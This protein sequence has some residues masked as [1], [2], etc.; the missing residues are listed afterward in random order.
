MSSSRPFTPDSMSSNNTQFVD[1]P[2]EPVNEPQAAPPIAGSLSSGG[3]AATEGTAPARRPSYLQNLHLPGWH[4]EQGSHVPHD[5]YKPVEPSSPWSHATEG[6]SAA[7]RPS[8]QES[9]REEVSSM[10]GVSGP[11]PSKDLHHGNIHMTKEELERSGYGYDA[12]R[13]GMGVPEA[14]G[15]D[16]DEENDVTASNSWNN[17]YA[18]PNDPEAKPTSHGQAADAEK[19]VAT[20]SPAQDAPAQGTSEEAKATDEKPDHILVKW[21][22]EDDREHNMQMSF[23]FRLYLTVIGGLMTLASTFASSAPSFAM[24]GVMEEFH[25]KE[26]V[27]KAAVFLFVGGYCFAPLIW[28]PLSEMFGRRPTFIASMIG[29]FAFNMGCAFCKNIGS[30]IVFRILAGAF[31]SAPLSNVAPMIGGLFSFK[32]LTAGIVLFAIA[33]M[34]GPCLGPI[35]GGYIY[36]SGASWRWVYRV[37]SAVAFFFVLIAVFT[38]PETLDALRLKMKAQRLRKE[39]GDN[40]YVAPIEIR[41]KLNPLQLAKT[42]LLKPIKLFF[43]EPML[44]AVTLYISFVYGTL[45]LLFDAY[46]VVFMEPEP[47][48]HG[49][50]PGSVGLVF[51]G[52]F[53]GSLVGAAYAI[54]VDNRHYIKKLNENGGKPPAPEIRL[55]MAMFGAPLLV[56]SLFWFAWT[57]YPSISFWSPLVAGGMFGCAMYTIFLGLM[58]YMTEVYLFSAASAI[59]ANTVVRSAFGVGFPMFGTGMYHNL[60][61]QWATTILAF[62]ALAMFPMPFILVKYGKKLRGMSKFAQT[63]DHAQ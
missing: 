34:S 42:V 5:P 14:Q 53:V 62:I 19:E 54:L 26:E 47:R 46:P 56:I 49:M 40:R 3:A 6:D 25:V 13:G 22:G 60:G 55:C 41:E 15:F 10:F 30:L 12:V 17:K 48:G 63:M 20:A 27:A 61:P 59:A 57:S 1:A 24:P 31:G 18:S 51:L 23:S 43:L 58:V 37:C 16:I 4:H 36:E 2:S 38:I 44:I 9:L 45:Y 52:Y 21:D 8:A 7:H 39:T 28:A 33:P 29:F 32:Y 50:K 35:V 11:R